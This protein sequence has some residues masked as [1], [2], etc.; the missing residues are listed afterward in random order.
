MAFYRK[1]LETLKAWKHRKNRKPLVLRGAR[2]VGKTTLVDSFAK[3]YSQYIALNLEKTKDKVYFENYT[4][5]ES[6]LQ[7]LILDRRLKPIDK[8][9]TLLFIDEIQEKPEAIA[10]LRYFY[11]DIPNLHVIAAGSLLEHAISKVKSFPV[12]RIEYLYLFPMNFKEFLWVH[13]MDA[14]IERLENPPIQASTHHV[15]MDWFHKYAMIGGM[16]EAIKTHKENGELSQLPRIYESI[17]ASYRED[18]SKYAKNETE[19]KVITHIMTTAPF[20]L[21]SRVTFQGFG[22]SNY[23][24]R[25]VGESFRALDDAK[26]IQLIFPGTSVEY[27]LITD[28]RKSPRLQF[29]DTGLLNHALSIQSE[30]IEI[31]DLSTSFKGA[32]LPHLITQEIISLNDIAYKKPNFWV[33]QK[34]ST[35]AEVD[36]VYTFKQLIIPI[37]I[38]SG[39]VGKMRSLHQF[40]NQAPHPYAVRMYAGEFSIE[41]HKTP[42]GTSFYL[43]NLPYYLATFIDVYLEYFFNNTKAL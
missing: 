1:Q 33:R 32:I 10:L 31:K 4:S 18:V 2:Q 37:E 16:P 40:V 23:R 19:E 9:D 43:M 22:K 41:Q 3:R 21:D 29:L 14:L 13:Q 42:E 26:I 8:N 15:A 34:K 17:W 7:A 27:P 6:I 28:F 39:K 24:S 25:E 30:L 12:G 11:E 36:L 5:A 38:K 20:Y 35:Q